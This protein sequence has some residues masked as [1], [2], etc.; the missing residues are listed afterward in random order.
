MALATDL[1]CVTL[2]VRVLAIAALHLHGG[3]GLCVTVD[4]GVR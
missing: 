2:Q 1:D 4:W 3:C